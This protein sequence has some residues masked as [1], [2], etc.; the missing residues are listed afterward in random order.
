MNYLLD[1][2]QDRYLINSFSYVDD[3]GNLHE[4]IKINEQ[5][6]KNNFNCTYGCGI[7]EMTKL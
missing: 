7:F 3:K 1:L 4:D 2:F 6:K 5:N